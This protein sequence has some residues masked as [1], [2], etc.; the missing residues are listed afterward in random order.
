MRRL[1]SSKVEDFLANKE[2]DI[3]SQSSKICS[4]LNK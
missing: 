2:S 1:N 4:E 3:K